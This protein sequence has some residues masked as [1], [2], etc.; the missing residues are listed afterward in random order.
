MRRRIACI[1]A[2]LACALTA[3]FA[4]A[5]S[6][7][8]RA[9]AEARKYAGTTLTVEWQGG[10]QALDPKNFSGPLWERLT[11]IKIKVVEV[12][13]TEVFSKIVLDYRSG[14]GTYDVVDVVPAWTP[15]LVQM[16]AL[17]PLDAY[18][19]R[20]GYRE[21]LKKI[22]PV[23]RDNWMTFGGRIY[24]LP[25][26]GDVLVLYYRKDIFANPELKKAFRAK[27][28]RELAPPQTW[29]QFA[30]AGAFLTD[31]L[32]AEKVYGASMVCDPAFAQYLFQERF[33]NEG[34]RFFDPA[35]M[36]ATINSPAG[37]GV[38]TAMR[39]ENKFMPPGVETFKFPENLAAF[40]NGTVA[41]T[42]SW[43]PVGRWAAGYGSNEQALAFV[44]KSKVAGNV[45]YALPP[46]GHPQLAIGHSLAVSS[47]SRNKEAAY[48]FIQWLNS[49]D[50]SLKRVQLPYT[51]RDPFRTSHYANPEYLGR[52]AD[53][54]DYLN[55]LKSASM[56]GL[57]DLSLIQTDK[58]EEALRQGFSRLWAGEDPK[59]ILDDVAAR[60][61][62]ITQS[63]GVA[64]QR[65]AYENWAA[66]PGAYPR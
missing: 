59:K 56:V 37:V 8:D 64:R 20:F 30:E 5:Q 47:R 3:A 52:W 17:E 19:D 24:A 31:A 44:P 42:V 39:D 2:A 21:E 28:G 46:G 61:D 22:A 43:P 16:G 32:K 34:G 38:M 33:R 53:A 9:V 36:K 26:D 7:A 62:E 54:G 27:Y 41:M 58:Y 23:Y 49:E 10:L 15:D 66:R 1:A 4:S 63:V 48:L 50:T 51:L 45:G 18:V 25:D 60:W 40:L 6:A 57:A 35:T 14:T 11:G 65:L 29:K 55:L 13:L 12:P